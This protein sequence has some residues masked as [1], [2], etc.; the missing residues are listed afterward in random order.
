MIAI[1]IL[2]LMLQAAPPEPPANTP[3]CHNYHDSEIHNCRCPK[4]M[5]EGG[6]HDGVPDRE[7]GQSWCGT[8]CL[9]G[10]CLCVSPVKVPGKPARESK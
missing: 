2:M 3:A 4:A 8:Y 10:K 9:H 7:K 6:H 5:M 1:A